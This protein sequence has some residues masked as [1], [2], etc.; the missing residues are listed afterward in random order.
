MTMT[1]EALKDLVE[2]A[3]KNKATDVSFFLN[4]AVDSDKIDSIDIDLWKN[5]SFIGT[6]AILFDKSECMKL[7]TKGI[8]GGGISRSTT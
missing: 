1:I 5:C 4:Y 7:K 6:V 3:E 8:A 2:L